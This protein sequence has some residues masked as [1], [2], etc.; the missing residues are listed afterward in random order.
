MIKKVTLL[1]GLLM[2]ASSILIAQTQ[3]GFV[4]TLGRPDKPSVALEGVTVRAEGVHNAVLS[5]K[6]GR[7]QMPMNDKRNGDS[8]FLQ[9]VQKKDYELADQSVVGRK[10]A[11]SDRVPLTV[12][13]VS[14]CKLTSSG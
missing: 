14:N 4:R 1:C 11:Y 13:M 7:F 3:Q 9:Q 6:D 10:Y 2:T 5:G 12:V 8:Y